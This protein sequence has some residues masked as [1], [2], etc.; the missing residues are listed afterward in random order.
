MN[1]PWGSHLYV[2]SLKND[3]NNRKSY[4]Y[5]GTIW[6]LPEAWQDM[7]GGWND[8]MGSKVQSKFLVIK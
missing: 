6:W 4:G 3:N 2:E 5:R 1:V 7:G 8:L